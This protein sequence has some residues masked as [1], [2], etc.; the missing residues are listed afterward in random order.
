M[1]AVVTARRF[2]EIYFDGVDDMLAQARSRL[3]R[4]SARAAY[5]EV[6]GGRAILVDIRPEAQR[7]TEGVVEDLPG[8]LVIDRN[9]LEWRLDPRS[10]TRLPLASYDARVVVLCQQ[11]YTSSLAADSLRQL[12]VWA[13]TDVVGGFAAWRAAGMPVRLPGQAARPECPAGMPGRNAR[14]ECPARLPE[15]R[16]SARASVR[17]S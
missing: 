17:S 3:D 2:E 11:G 14:P 1:T 10:E 9:V 15:I 4:V 16:P 8:V 7:V 12:G 5:Q 13:A 6:I